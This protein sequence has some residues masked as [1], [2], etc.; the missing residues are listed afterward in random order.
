MKDLTGYKILLIDYGS[1][2]SVAQRLARDFGTVF[3][4]GGPYVTNS[5]PVHNPFDIGYNVPNIVKVKEWVEAYEESDAVMFVDSMEPTLQNWMKNNGKPVFGSVFADR[6]EHDRLFIKQTLADL[7]LPVGA[8]SVA[9]GLDELEQL[10][11][12]SKGGFTKSSLRGNGETWRHRDWRLSKRQLKKLRH[13]M[14]LYEN[15][16]TY[17]LEDLLDPVAEFGYD[18][19]IC[20][21]NYIDVSMCGFE[22]KDKS[23]LGKFIYY[24]QLPE[25]IRSVNNAFA[26]IF[27][28]MGYNGHYSN[29]IIVTKDKRGFLLDNTCRFPS[30]P[31]ELMLEAYTNYSE[32]VWD[33]AHGRMPYIEFKD[34]WGVQLIIKSDIAE[35][36]PSPILVPD[37]YKGNVKIKNLSI[38]EDGTWYFVPSSSLGMK[39]IGSITFTAPTADAAIKGA[40]QIAE[41]V[42]GFDI[43][44]DVDS[45]SDAKKSMAKLSKSGISYI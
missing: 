5:F 6:L 29:E 27:N 8:Y 20:G 1:G 23:Y 44:I 28:E 2:I 24:N 40:T 12:N 38:D 37:E 13:E 9:T 41:A 42:Q 19:F 18:G 33:I 3:Y 45:L 36:D 39:E 31:G 22:Q 26:P 25:Q 7:G 17:I 21:G 4:W 30:P 11:L 15:R 32:I 16:E 43:H 10:L 35:D 34:Q 14:G